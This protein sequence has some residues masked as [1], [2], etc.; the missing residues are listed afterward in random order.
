MFKKNSLFIVLM[1]V[2]GFL[3]SLLKYKSRLFSV[4]GCT[5]QMM[6]VQ[7]VLGVGIGS[8]ENAI[9]SQTPNLTMMGQ[10]I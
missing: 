9:V 6:E 8:N 7:G 1:F 10:Q 5:K 2:P 3:S 4:S